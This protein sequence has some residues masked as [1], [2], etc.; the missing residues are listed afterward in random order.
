MR[1]NEI[2]NSIIEHLKANLAEL[3]IE[4][5]PEKPDQFNLLHSKGA[6]L[7]HYQGASYSPTNSTSSIVQEKK[8]EFSATVVMRHLRSN[9]GA[10][11]VL[12]RVR[13]LLTGF[14]INGC[15]KISMLKESFLSENAGIWQYAINFTLTAQNI[16]NQDKQDLPLFKQ[17]ECE[18]SV[19][20]EAKP[21]YADVEIYEQSEEI[22]QEES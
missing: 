4:G 7:V 19:W 17:G 16:E 21:F 3:H 8:L 9:D 5:F 11:E 15:T 6:V 13:E 20:N 18:S 14:K 1:I 10:Y 2:E 22:S 12:D